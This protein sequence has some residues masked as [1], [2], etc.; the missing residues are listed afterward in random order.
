MTARST[1]RPHNLTRRS[2]PHLRHPAND[3]L[4]PDAQ[5]PLLSAWVAMKL[6]TTLAARTVMPDT[7]AA[8]LPST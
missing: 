4:S 6:S 8:L 7:V 1:C 2:V 5:M 3:M